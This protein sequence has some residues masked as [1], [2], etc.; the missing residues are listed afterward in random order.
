MK[1]FIRNR[2]INLTRDGSIHIFPYGVLPNTGAGVDQVLDDKAHASVFGDLVERAERDPLYFGIEHHIYEA[3]QNSEAL[4]WGKVFER[5]AD[6][7]YCK[8]ELTDIGETALRNKRFR[9]TSFVC[10]SS[11]PG[12]IEK[13]D[14]KRV[15]IL[16]I[17]TVGFTNLPN[18]RDILTPIANRFVNLQEIK[19]EER[20]WAKDEFHKEVSR[21]RH[22]YKMTET[23]AQDMAVFLNKDMAHL[24][25][26]HTQASL[27]HATVQELCNRLDVLIANR[28]RIYPN[29][30]YDTA[31]QQVAF[32]EPKLLRAI[33][34][35]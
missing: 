15:R 33:R 11:K 30:S 25:G 27:E 6:G 22:A 29:I 17:D 28:R 34:E 5:R 16:K 18:G 14:G 8:P 19:D 31:R 32:A 3:S 10:D 2:E 24:S 9:W 23:D 21:I 4:G 1:T 20:I 12:A 13:L 35:K 26:Y 7:I